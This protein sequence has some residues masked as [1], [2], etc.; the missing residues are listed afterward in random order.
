MG[1]EVA[2]KTQAKAVEAKKV[3][4]KKPIEKSKPDTKELK[5]KVIDT[6]KKN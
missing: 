5:K 2:K 4:V 3:E 1:K 6:K